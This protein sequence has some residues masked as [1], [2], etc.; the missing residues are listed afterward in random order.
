MAEY[1][2]ELGWGEYVEGEHPNHLLH[3]AR[4]LVDYG[5]V[6]AMETGEWPWLPPPAAKETVKNIP[7]VVVDNDSTSCPICLKLFQKG[8]KVKEL[9]CRHGFHAECILTWLA[10][11]N[12]CPFCRY[13]LPTD[14]KSY[15]MFRKAKKRAEQ[16]KEDLETLHN[17]MYR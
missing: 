4:I 7:E 15:E 12:S 1:F 6:S 14:N 9:P 17:S 13:E 10:K 8:E 2:E 11:T 5:V 16:R 3:M